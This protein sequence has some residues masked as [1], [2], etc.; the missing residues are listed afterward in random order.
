MIR[1]YLVLFFVAMLVYSMTGCKKETSEIHLIPAFEGDTTTLSGLFK[2]DEGVNAGY[3][4]FMDFS[5]GAQT[6]AQRNSWDFGVYCGAENRLII[7]HSMGAA[8]IA[9]SKTSLT[10]VTES[11]TTALQTDGTLLVSQTIGNLKNVDP[12]SGTFAN[13]LSGTVFAEVKADPDLH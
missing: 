13:Y 7:N 12:V 9:L 11:D 2:S 4:V 10:D 3:S 1:N 8:A 6:R 5:K